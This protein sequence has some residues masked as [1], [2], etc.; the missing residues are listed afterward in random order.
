[1]IQFPGMNPYLEG[2]LFKDLHNALA[3]RIRA[4][5]T[6]L[7]RPR[8]AARLE[9]SVMQDDDP[10]ELNIVY[11]DVEVVRTPSRA[12]PAQGDRLEATPATL[13]LP[14]PTSVRLPR[15]EVKDV[16]SGILVT[17]IEILSYVNKRQP[18]LQQY[19]QKRERL[20]RDGVHLVEVDLLRRETRPLNQSSIPNSHY[21]VTITRIRQRVDIWAFQMQEPLPIVPIPLIPPDQDVMLD[22]NQAIHQVYEE[23]DYDLSIDYHKPPAPPPLSEADQQWLRSVINT[24]I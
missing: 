7:I 24:G 8:Y 2:Y 20:I 12:T 19:T 18:G 11:P 6:P 10:T 16:E 23:A 3:S 5:L 4:Q 17:C 15:V 21:R 9:I 1:M 22:L 14:A 13:T